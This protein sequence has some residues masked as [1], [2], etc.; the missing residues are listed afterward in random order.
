MLSE[1]L[2]VNAAINPVT[3]LFKV[4]N[5][6]L[7]ENPHYLNMME[8]LF[9]ESIQVLGLQKQKERLLEDLYRVCRNTKNNRSSMLRDIDSGR[10][11]EID[12]ISGYILRLGKQ[13]G[14]D[15]SKTRMMYESIKGIEWEG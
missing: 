4:E 9:E 13:K 10:K 11:T 1:K 8:F 2:L 14:I 5:G 15:T 6:M 7:L 12:S 3:A